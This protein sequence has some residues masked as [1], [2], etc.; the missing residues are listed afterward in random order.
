MAEEQDVPTVGRAAVSAFLGGATMPETM[1]AAKQAEAGIKPDLPEQKGEG[2]QTEAGGPE[3]PVEEAHAELKDLETRLEAAEGRMD[4]HA[5]TLRRL[6]LTK[7]DAAKII[8]TL[9]VR[10]TRHRET[11]RLLNGRVSITFQT[12]LV[13][14]G[15]LLNEVMETRRPQYY[16]GVS[17]EAWRHYLAASIVRYNDLR[18]DDK[19]LDDYDTRVA[20]VRGL[21]EPVFNMLVIELQEFDAKIKALLKP[22]FLRHF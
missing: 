7:E 2:D 6:N 13:A 3:Q 5:E 17:A 22:T 19:T 12:R 18:F 20:W 9:M 16:A 21:Q 11:L 10:G 14:D 8:D 15:D 1:R 4:R